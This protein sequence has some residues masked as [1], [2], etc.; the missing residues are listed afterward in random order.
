MNDF[1]DDASF[2]FHGNISLMTMSKLIRVSICAAAL[3]VSLMIDSC[4]VLCGVVQ[5]NNNTDEEYYLL[6]RVIF[7]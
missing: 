4:I 1:N 5:H 6:L 3:I 2:Y 7:I